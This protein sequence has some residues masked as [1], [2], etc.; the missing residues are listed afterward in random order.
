MKWLIIQTWREEDHQELQEEVHIP[1]PGLISRGTAATTGILL[2]GGTWIR[3][4]VVIATGIDQEIVH[5]EIE[6]TQRGTIRETF[7]ESTCLETILLG[8][9]PPGTCL[10]E[11]DLLGPRIYPER[12][13]L[14][15]TTTTIHLPEATEETLLE[16]PTEVML[17][18]IGIATLT[19]EAD[20]GRELHPQGSITIRTDPGHPVLAPDLL[21]QLL[22]LPTGQWI[23][24][25]K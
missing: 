25:L 20:R 18:L 2:D 22:G 13:I 4:L 1:R 12:D 8:T 15:G 6:V 17:P 16:G 3:I 9:L 19:E 14:Q 5:Q 10:L 11:T 23:K 7:Q 24:I 21:L